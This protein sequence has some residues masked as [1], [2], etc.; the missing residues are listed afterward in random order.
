MNQG[1]RTT[2]KIV[3]SALLLSAAAMGQTSAKNTE[4]ASKEHHS[5]MSKV[6]FWHR[7]NDASKNAKQPAAKPATT[8]PV[9]SKQSQSKQAQVNPAVAK[10]SQTSKPQV[11]PVSAKQPPSKIEQKHN[12]TKSASASAKKSTEKAPSAKPGKP[13]QKPVTPQNAQASQTDSAK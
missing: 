10:Q 11:K 7:H 5:K 8:N 1:F 13:Q 4:T 6:A 12:T 2:Q 9:Q 3:V